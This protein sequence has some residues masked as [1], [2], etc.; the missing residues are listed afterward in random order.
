MVRQSYL[1]L[2]DG[3]RICAVS[4]AQMDRHNETSWSLVAL[5]A[6]AAGFLLKWSET[7]TTKLRSNQGT[8]QIYPHL[9]WYIP[10]PNTSSSSSRLRSRLALARGTGALPARGTKRRVT[11]VRRCLVWLSVST[12]VGMSRPPEEIIA[13]SLTPMEKPNKYQSPERSQNIKQFCHKLE[14]KPMGGLCTRLG[15]SS[16][17]VAHPTSNS[18]PDPPGTPA[19]ASPG[20]SARLPEESNTKTQ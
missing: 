7:T 4:L 1:L 6:V 5:I 14:A 16:Q 9:K 11:T 15:T 20:R 8:P 19:K 3:S 17:D 10:L 13:G 18:L 2:I 12:S